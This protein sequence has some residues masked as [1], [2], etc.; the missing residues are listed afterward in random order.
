MG[1]GQ[2]KDFVCAA[3]SKPGVGQA[4]LYETAL[5][6]PG[7][8]N[9][10][11]AGGMGYYNDF[12]YD[13]TGTNVIFLGTAASASTPAVYE[14]HRSDGSVVQLSPAGDVVGSFAHSDDWS[15]IAYAAKR[16]GSFV[17]DQRVLNRALPGQAMQL[18]NPAAT[19]GVILYTNYASAYFITK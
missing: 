12:R 18:S 2:I 1:P 3:P 11:F 13:E 5:S 10:I 4:A 8:V 17:Y 19:T 7:T 16:S 15:M 9:T 6:T 14:W